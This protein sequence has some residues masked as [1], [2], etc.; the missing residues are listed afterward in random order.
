VVVNISGYGSV[1]N[2]LAVLSLLG[3]YISEERNMIIAEKFF[4]SLVTKY[5]K[6]TVYTADGGT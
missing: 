1:L 3:I 6:H 2:Q 4:K 5:G